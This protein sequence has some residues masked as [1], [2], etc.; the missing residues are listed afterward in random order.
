MPIPSPY[1]QDQPRVERGDI[2][3][4]PPRRIEKGR[5]TETSLDCSVSGH[6][7]L[8]VGRLPGPAEY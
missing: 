4:A 1:L 6:M 5:A 2:F 7:V 3:K 8:V